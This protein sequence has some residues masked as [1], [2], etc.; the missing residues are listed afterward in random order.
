MDA[1]SNLHSEIK[2]CTQCSLRQG[3]T[4]VVP[5]EG[6]PEAG[7]VFFAEAPGAV[8]DE[9]GRPLIGRSGT[10]FRIELARAGIKENEVYLSNIVRC[11]PPENRDPLPEEIESCWTWTL[12]TLQVIRPK[13][14]VPMGRPALVT[15]SQKLGF[16]KKVGQNPIMKLAGIPFFVE[17]KHFFVFPIFHPA[18][19]IRRSSLKP[20]FRAHLMYLAK[21]IPDWMRR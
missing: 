17:E 3:C 20:E 11:R 7:V 1:L 6:N 4:Q 13:V 8:E 21:A 9:R 15:L 19:A 18:F 16:H 5:G 14:I 2:A 12:K 10:Y